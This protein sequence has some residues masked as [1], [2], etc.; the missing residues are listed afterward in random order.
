MSIS[1]DVK[2]AYGCDKESCKMADRLAASAELQE[3]KEALAESPPD[4]VM[5][6][7]KNAKKY[8]QPENALSKEISLSTGGTFQGCSHRQHLGSQIGICAR[9]IPPGK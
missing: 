3:L 9:Q 8:I 4:P 5:P 6:N 2:Q 1:G 7:S